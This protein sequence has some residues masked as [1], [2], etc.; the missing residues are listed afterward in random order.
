M[1][2]YILFYFSRIFLFYLRAINYDRHTFFLGVQQKDFSR[3]QF[4]QGTRLG[5]LWTFWGSTLAEGEPFHSPKTGSL[6]GKHPSCLVPDL[7]GIYCCDPIRVMLNNHLAPYRI[8]PKVQPPQ[9][10]LY[11][12]VK[13]GLWMKI[14]MGISP[15]SYGGQ[16]HN[17]GYLPNYNWNCTP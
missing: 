1:Y 15:R 12:R 6:W 9:M 17:D 14:T 2:H 8:M 4:G 3:T 13:F 16:H 10:V 11:F 7:R 5:H